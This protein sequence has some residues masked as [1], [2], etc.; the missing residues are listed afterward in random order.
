MKTLNLETIGLV[1]LTH[2]ESTKCNGGISGWGI[3]GIVLGS[4][5]GVAAVGVGIG[6]YLWSQNKNLGIT[7][8]W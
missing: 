2:E 6:A 4:L 7:G 8:P 1:E 3:F 5:V